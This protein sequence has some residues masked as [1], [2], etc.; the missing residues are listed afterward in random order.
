MT[1]AYEKLFNTALAGDTRHLSRSQWVERHFLNPVVPY[2]LRDDPTGEWHAKNQQVYRPDGTY[3][4]GLREGDEIPLMLRPYQKQAMNKPDKLRA[5]KWGRRCMV[6]GTPVLMADGSYKD[7]ETVEPGDRVLTRRMSDGSLEAKPVHLQWDN[8]VKDVYEITL[9]NGR[10]I[11]C[12]ANH[13]LLKCTNY[14]GLYY[15]DKPN[16]YE[17]TSIEDGLEEGDGVVMAA[18]SDSFGSVHEPEIGKFLGYMITDGYFGMNRQT[19]KFTNTNR[20]MIDEM[21]QIT[22]S[23][24][25]LDCTTREKGNGWDIHLTDSHKGSTNPVSTYLKGIDC[26]DTKAKRKTLPDCVWDWDRETM[27][28]FIN[29]MIS[30]DGCVYVRSRKERAPATAVTICSASKKLLEETR[31]LLMK[32]GVNGI[33]KTEDRVTT[34]PAGHQVESVLY[35]L[36]ITDLDSLTLLMEEMGPVYGKEEKSRELVAA[37]K[38]KKNSRYPRTP[39]G[40]WMQTRIA[41]IEHKGKEATYDIGVEDNHNFIAEGVLVHNTGKSFEMALEVMEEALRKNNSKV[42]VLAPAENQVRLLFDDYLRPLLRSYKHRASGRVGIGTDPSEIG[43]TVDYA[44]IKDTQKPQELQIRGRDGFQSIIRG[45]VI[46]E[47]ARGQSPT[48]LVMDEADYGDS[49]QI[50]QIA[51]PMLATGPSTRLLMVSTPSGRADTFF[52]NAFDSNRWATSHITFEKLPHYGPELRDEL[53]ELSGGADTNTFKREY[54]A[55]WG[56]S[57]EGVFNQIALN[58]SY[59]I[60]PYPRVMETYEKRNNS[61]TPQL[62][63]AETSKSKSELAFYNGV[64][65][66]DFSV[67]RN[68]IG[69]RS[70]YRP[71]HKGKGVITVGTDWNDL[72]GMQTVMIWWPPEDML[73]SGALEVARYKYNNSTPVT[74]QRKKTGDGNVFTYKIGHDNGDPGGDH[75][76]SET[77]GIIIW[78]GRLE[79]GS[80]TWQSAANRVAAIMAIPNFVD[81]WYVDRGYGEQVHSMIQQIMETGQWIADMHSTGK[82]RDIAPDPLKHMRRFHPE[83]DSGATGKI[84]RTI[85]FGDPYKYREFDFTKGEGSYKDVMISLAKRAVAGRQLLFPYAQVVGAHKENE[86]GSYKTEEIDFQK[87]E[88]VERE[89]QVTDRDKM[90]ENGGDPARGMDVFGGLVTQMQTTRVDGYTPTGKPRYKGDWHAVDGLMLAILA[91]WENY[92]D[93]TSANMFKKDTTLRTK[94]VDDIFAASQK[95]TMNTGRRKLNSTS[96][97]RGDHF[98]RKVYKNPISPLRAIVRG[99]KTPEEVGVSQDDMMRDAASYFQERASKE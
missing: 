45:L 34:V 1:E 17:W 49:E 44:I 61:R 54:L 55:Q 72:A 95:A 15:H 97:V 75:D 70:L 33:I 39:N 53:I 60:T 91:Y 96:E 71:E 85:G 78:H 81:A 74:A 35:S 83:K 58:Q 90:V 80:F 64:R 24:F 68:P 57:T 84:Y 26:F 37:L 92:T 20:R 14:Q 48:F 5:H 94:Q 79:S 27:F 22:Q 29:R 16:S 36:E 31:L 65:P 13:P 69:G 23:E 28:A 6:A 3:F 25:G 73:R 87:G 76:L 50:K 21:Q 43:D 99:E 52:R 86:M 93:A 38:E 2:A 56:S 19:P 66:L 30:G 42:L 7:I 11:T 12:T 4:E 63:G 98:N 82:A 9:R 32:A 67:P 59:I 89:D 46:S 40:R 88:V 62:A 51:S 77:K 10:S 41:S 18:D 47:S 8:G